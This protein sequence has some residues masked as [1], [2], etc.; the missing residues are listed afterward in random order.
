MTT[1]LAAFSAVLGAITGSFLN[2]C[3]HR[4]PRGISLSDPKRSFCPSC[5]KLIP[6]Y[7]NIPVVSWSMLWGKCSGC[8]ARI[9]PRYVLVEILT[10][11]CFLGLWFRYGLPLAPAYWI[12]FSLLIAATFIDIEHFIIPDEIT[13]GGTVAGVACAAAL[14]ALMDTGSRLVS[15]GL[16]LAGA[17]LGAG[18]LWLVVEG[19]KIAFGRKKHVF[20]STREFQWIRDGDRADLVVGEETHR[21][22]DIFSRESDVLVLN[23][24]GPVMCDGREL[25]DGPLRFR[26]DRLL[27]G[28]EEHKLDHLDRISGTLDSVVIPREAMGFGDVKFLAC[29]GAFLGWQAVLFTFFASSIIGCVAGIAGILLARGKARTILPFGPYL[30]LGAA[31]WLFGGRELADWYFSQFQR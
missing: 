20:E 10:A 17:A 4:M 28:G 23:P 2:A 12:F 3:I 31:L 13:L 15:G 29:I 21:W 26:Y 27:I 7:E 5:N 16:S 22:E 1:P 30:A 19:G 25:P 6:W 14:P 24:A 11:G 9:S 8:G 18:L